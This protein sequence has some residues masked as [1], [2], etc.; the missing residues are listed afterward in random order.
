MA[1]SA[2]ARY[3]QYYTSGSAARKLE[4]V[5]SATVPVAPKVKRQKRKAIYV[6]P[7]SFAGIAV[8]VVMLVLMTVGFVRLQRINR[9]VAVM[10]SYVTT[11]RRE[12][13]TLE[14]EFMTGFDANDVERMA[15]G[16]GMVPQSQAQR[17][18]VRV[19]MPQEAEPAGT[20]Q[21]LMVRLSALFA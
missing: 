11:L 12:N 10:E 7:V 6:D 13:A 2:R 9:E 15:L 5:M 20:W 1:G 16:L 17:V 14:K 3:I 18:S 19:E 4:V 21:A 8:A